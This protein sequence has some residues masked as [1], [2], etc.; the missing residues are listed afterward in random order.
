MYGLLKGN[1]G[2]VG[3][4]CKGNGKKGRALTGGEKE[5]TVNA[6]EKCICR[7]ADKGGGVRCVKGK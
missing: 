3:T 7:A 5:A 2:R 6:E 4:V 1:S